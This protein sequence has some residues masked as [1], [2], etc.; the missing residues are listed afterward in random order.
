MERV[1]TQPGPLTDLPANQMSGLGQNPIVT[2]VAVKAY[3]GDYDK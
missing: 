2:A 1:S 3:Y